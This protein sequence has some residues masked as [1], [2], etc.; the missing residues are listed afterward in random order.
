[1]TNRPPRQLTRNR[2]FTCVLINQ[3]ATPGL[4]SLMAGRI[5]SG[6]GQLFLALAGFVLMTVWMFQ[7][8]YGVAVQE[9]G[10]SPPRDP[11]DWMW[12]WGSILFGVSWCWALASSI[13]LLRQ[14]KTAEQA[15][16]GGV[17]PRMTEPPS[18]NPGAS[19]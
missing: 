7:F 10:Q 3:L 9:L 11:Q 13:S 19:I 8:F 4:G 16:P 15:N 6:V 12:T 2:L 1:M 18:G 14:A 17:P 5:V